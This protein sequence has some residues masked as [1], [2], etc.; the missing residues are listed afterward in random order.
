M[1][2]GILFPRDYRS[3][4]DSDGSSHDSSPDGV[5][6]PVDELLEPEEFSSDSEDEEWWERPHAESGTKVKVRTY[7]S[8]VKSDQKFVK[9]KLRN[10]SKIKSSNLSSHFRF[11]N[12]IGLKLHRLEFGNAKWTRRRAASAYA[13]IP[14]LAW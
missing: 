11:T 2:C 8:T 6:S 13:P 3:E 7:I 14:D 4:V 10:S 9:K 1:G 12:P 5:D